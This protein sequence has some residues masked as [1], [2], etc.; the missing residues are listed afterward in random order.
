MCRS[1]VLVVLRFSEQQSRASQEPH[2]FVLSFPMIANIVS[3]YMLPHDYTQL[4]HSMSFPMMLLLV[5]VLAAPGP[6]RDP[7]RIP[8]LHGPGNPAVP[9]IRRK[10][11]HPKSAESDGES[12]AGL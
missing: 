10:G 8:P 7:L 5:Q 3:I 2:F 12:G 4:L 6:S 11:V 1:A 9:E